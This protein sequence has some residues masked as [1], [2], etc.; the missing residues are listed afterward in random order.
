MNLEKSLQEELWIEKA[1]KIQ[2]LI[3]SFRENA[4]RCLE[5]LERW[6]SLI[7]VNPGTAQDIISEVTGKI[8]I[9]LEE[10]IVNLWERRKSA[11]QT[12]KMLIREHEHTLRNELWTFWY[13][14]YYDWKE[15]ILQFGKS[16]ES[17]ARMIG[18]YRDT[19][20][21]FDHYNEDRLK[22]SFWSFSKV[23]ITNGH[24]KEIK[25]LWSLFDLCI[26]KE[27]ERNYNKYWE[28]LEV[29]IVFWEE[30]VEFIF[31]NEVKE[32]CGTCYS[33]KE[34]TELIRTT[35]EQLQ[36]KLHQMGIVEEED[37]EGQQNQK[38]R[39]YKTWFTLP[40]I[41]KEED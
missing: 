39:K 38:K 3:I 18:W 11:S 25:T 31:L 12:G 32:N 36:G 8:K 5:L 2:E 14:E 6:K 9:V 35:L 17:I 20:S 30:S 1:R 33:G 34:W 15:R 16:E 21:V 24:G 13:L 28:N 27:I 40:L 22:V 7:E 4:E 41:L 23:T 19:D 29:E 26:V 10:Q 37:K